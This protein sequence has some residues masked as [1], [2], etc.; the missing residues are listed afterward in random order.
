MD[1]Q[2]KDRATFTAGDSLN[3]ANRVVA[4]TFDYTSTSRV[5]KDYRVYW[6]AQVYGR[7]CF[8]DVQY[9]LANCPSHDA[10]PQNIISDIKRSLRKRVYQCLVEEG[11]FKRGQ[12]L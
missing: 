8:S 6:E 2:V 3:L 11:R 5:A 7:L 9:F 1:D 12:T 4:R 10:V